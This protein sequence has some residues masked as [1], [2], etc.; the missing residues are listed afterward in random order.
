MVGDIMFIKEQIENIKKNDPAI[1]SNLE[2]ILY[3]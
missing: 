1:H 2:D 3:T